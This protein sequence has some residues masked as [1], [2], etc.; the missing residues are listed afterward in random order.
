M[1]A[2]PHEWPRVRQAWIEASTRDANLRELTARW[3]RANRPFFG[4][5]LHLL[6]HLRGCCVMQRVRCAGFLRD[7][8]LIRRA[9]LGRPLRRGGGI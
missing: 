8:F 3:E 6:L 9:L 4:R 5:L 1:L 2:L 7:Y